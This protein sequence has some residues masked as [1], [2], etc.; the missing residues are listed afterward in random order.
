MRT[1]PLNYVPDQYLYLYL[2]RYLYL[3]TVRYLTGQPAA[4]PTLRSDAAAGCYVGVMVFSAGFIAAAVY[5]SACTTVPRA[6]RAMATLLVNLGMTAGIGLG[7][8]IAWMLR[9]VLE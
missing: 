8:T 7:I 4:D 2:N 3:C 1:G 9:E 6:H 5:S